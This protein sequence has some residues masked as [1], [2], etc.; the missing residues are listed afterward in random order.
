MLNFTS[1]TLKMFKLIN[2]TYNQSSANLVT[3]ASMARKMCCSTSRASCSKQKASP[4][5]ARKV[6]ACL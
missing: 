6:K 5:K 1:G 3:Q 2:Y 4:C